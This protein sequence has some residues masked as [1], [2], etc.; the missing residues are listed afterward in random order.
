MICSGS[1]LKHIIDD[2]EFDDGLPANVVVHQRHVDVAQRSAA[3]HEY[4][5]SHHVVLGSTELALFAVSHQRAFVN[6]LAPRLIT[7][8]DRSLDDDEETY[9]GRRKLRA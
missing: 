9:I 3:S 8:D 6:E 4:R 2:V 5:A 1:Y 7:N